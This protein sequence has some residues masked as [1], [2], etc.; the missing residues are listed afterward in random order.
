VT[1][2]LRIGIQLPEVEREVRW[3]EYVDLARTAEEV[4]VD[5]IWL[6]DHLLYRG[7][8]GHERGPWEVW[9]MLAAL[10]GA[11]E[12]VTLGPL[13]ACTAFH[14][15]AV[16]AKMA[17]TVDEISG[18]RLVLGLGAGWNETE[19]RSFGLPY[20]QRVARFAEAFAVIAP[21]VRGERATLAGQFSS[22]DEAVLLPASARATERPLPLMIGSTGERMLELT[23]GTVEMW[24][25]W[26]TEFGNTP[27]GFAVLNR[28]VSAIAERVGRP[29]AEIDRSACVLVVVD[30]ASR[31]RRVPEGCTPL[32]GDPATV[33]AAMHAYASAGADEVIL[34][35]NPIDHES[36][37][38]LGRA[39][40]LLD[41]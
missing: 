38:A 15:P 30:P 18:G 37:R 16:L 27:E 32:A 1:R 8:N 22:V 34:V 39:L 7:E 33:A 4:G 5:S 21:L 35:A 19:F 25:T 23:L 41:D 6:G 20:D 28:R 3:A 10:A 14:P 26:F 36:I 2:P 31:E 11:T 13:V 12:R 40:A 29:A 9:T 17:A 24:N